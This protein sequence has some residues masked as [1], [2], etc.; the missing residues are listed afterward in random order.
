MNKSISIHINCYS[1]KSYK[2]K[3]RYE[4]HCGIANQIESFLNDK[5]NRGEHET[6][7]Y[8]F[9]SSKFGITASLIAEWLYPYGGSENS[10]R[11]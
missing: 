9:M 10:I 11:L 8:D 5:I 6:I 4:Y 7:S 1:G 3:N 2:L